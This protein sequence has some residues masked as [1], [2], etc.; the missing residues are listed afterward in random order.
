MKQVG[1]SLKLRSTADREIYLAVDPL[2]FTSCIMDPTITGPEQYKIARDVQRILH[3][4]KFFY[5]KEDVKEK[6]LTPNSRS[7]RS[8][9]GLAWRQRGH[10][11][12]REK[13]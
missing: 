7:T 4:Y 6:R 3:D 1:G 13:G 5:K 9:C 2:N 12:L 8:S 11:G 10:G